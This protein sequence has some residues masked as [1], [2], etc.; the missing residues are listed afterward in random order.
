LW[1][2]ESTMVKDTIKNKLRTF[3]R[4]Y[5]LNKIIKGGIISLGLMILLAILIII[6]EWIL[7]SSGDV[8]L[9][10]L[11][12][13]ALAALVII[14]YY[15]F[16][17]LLQLFR[18]RKGLSD[19]QAANIVGAHFPEISDKLLNY[20]QLEKTAGQE[21]QAELLKASINQKAKALTPFDFRQSVSFKSNIP[22]L[23]RFA[24]VF[25]LVGIMLSLFPQQFKSS[26]ERVVQFRKEFVKPQPFTFQVMNV[27]LSTEENSS[28]TI[29]ASTEGKYIPEKA[30]LHFGEEKFLMSRH[31]TTFQYKVPNISRNTD[32]FFSSGKVQSKTY[33][34][35]VFALPVI[36]DFSLFLDFPEYTRL[37]KDTVSNNGDVFVPEGTTIRWKFY[38]KDITRI[39]FETKDSVQGVTVEQREAVEIRRIFSED[40]PYWVYA[41][42]QYLKGKDTLSYTIGIIKDE[43]PQID[44]R[45]VDDSLQ[46]FR[47][48]FTGVISDDY[49]FTDLRFIAQS[50]DSNI[51]NKAIDITEANKQ[52]FYFSQAFSDFREKAASLTYFF[53]VTDNDAV[54][55]PKS[56]ISEKRKLKFPTQEEVEEDKRRQN[57][58]MR[59]GFE[60]QK[61]Q[62]EDLNKK[63]QK[64]K[65]SLLDKEG[66][67]WEE[68]E[69]MKEV[70]KDFEKLKQQQA[71]LRKELEQNRK[72]E[73]ELSDTEKALLEKQKELEELM[74]KV[75]D[76]EMKAMME[77]IRKLMEELTDKNFDETLRQMEM[78][79]EEMER[80]VDRSLELFK[81]LE[82]EKG[83]DDLIKKTEKLRDEQSK[84]REETAEQKPRDINKR[85]E[86][87]ES[88]QKELDSIRKNSQELHEKNK[89]LEKPNNFKPPQK[90]MDKGQDAMEESRQQLDQNNKNKSI[91]KMQEAEE[92]LESLS[93]NLKMQ[94]QQMEDENQAEDAES[95]K[96]ILQNLIQLSFDQEKLMNRFQSINRNDPSYVEEIQQQFELREKAKIVKDSLIALTKRQAMIEPFVMKE[97]EDIESNSERAIDYL[98]E[99]NVNSGVARQQ[100]AMMHM[101]NLALMLSEA[102]KNMQASMNAKGSG[103]GKPKPGQGV[104]KMSEIKKMQQE[105]QKNMQ[106]MKDGKG[107]EKP[108]GQKPS[109]SEE[110]A[111]MA[112][113]QAAIRRKLNQYREELMKQGQGDQGLSKTI[114]KMEENETDLVNKRITEE[115]IERQKEIL[116]RL[117]ESEKAEREQ[118]K[119][120]RREG[121][122]ARDALR[123]EPEAMEFEKMI[124]K[125]RDILRA[126]PPEM[127]PYYKKKVNEYFIEGPKKQ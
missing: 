24:P 56:A 78:K 1:L 12:L 29:K 9:M 80:Q 6:P 77:E 63:I 113:K 92:A 122:T 102:L 87:Q 75:L 119:E 3:I 100:Y 18:L 126:V 108:G 31:G 111:R 40:Q 35:E 41:E 94:Q 83:L 121:T 104:P 36:L 91:E 96:Q 66:P 7:Y 39:F 117:L 69:K 45:E 90:E 50:N 106:Q 89:Q 23:L 123:S 127:N 8:R 51:I 38:P 115:L 52:Q 14:T 79:A 5:Y 120:K 47:K 37:E 72:F 64:L 60:G 2:E 124:E 93:M 10:L 84:L 105:L 32:F 118:E 49:G 95:L 17:P 107:Q 71:Q 19:E 28:F 34:L 15:I 97:I 109:M 44:I 70:M 13:F 61:E 76:E 68:T 20:I 114:K 88:L 86:E 99:R 73:E 54:N 85:S 21:N 27:S 33:S 101:N 81:Q 42:N 55:G 59:S 22:F 116:T 4:K 46:Y 103:K 25:V 16:I 74:D 43:F 26:A 82:F 67:G 98:N 30:Y 62:A 110:L 53:K 58:E 57:T 48:Y 112:A 11:L 65:E 125:G